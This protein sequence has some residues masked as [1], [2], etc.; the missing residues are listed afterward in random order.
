MLPAHVCGPRAAWSRRR[1]ACW[2]EHPQ[3]ARYVMA[4]WL[5]LP[6]HI[7]ILYTKKTQHVCAL[8]VLTMRW[9]TYFIQ[10]KYM[11]TWYWQRDFDFLQYRKRPLASNAH[12]S[13]LVDA[14]IT[15]R[16]QTST[17][18]GTDSHKMTS[19]T[20]PQTIQVLKDYKP[21]FSYDWMR[22]IWVQIAFE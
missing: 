17:T 1:C 10:K 7:R 12:S 2:L 20:A 11:S 8:Y 9:S 3:T 14:A 4:H 19:S 5:E 6:A 13:L 18:I 16:R 15:T 22:A 21:I